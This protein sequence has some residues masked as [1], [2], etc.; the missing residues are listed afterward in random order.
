MILETAFIHIDRRASILGTLIAFDKMPFMLLK[1]QRSGIKVI[2]PFSC[3]THIVNSTI[4]LDK[5]IF[6]LREADNVTCS[7]LFFSCTTHMSMK[8][9][10]FINSTKS[11]NKTFFSLIT[12]DLVICSRLH[13]YQDQLSEGAQWLS[14][15]VLDL[16]L[17]GRRFKPHRRH[18]VV[19]LEQDK[20]ILA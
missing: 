3:S 16:R 14:G 9:V 6:L 5:A 4:S 19:V 11:T 10:S 15:R 20:F 12:A 17:R 8:L 1:H 18:C 2:K 7:R 13:F